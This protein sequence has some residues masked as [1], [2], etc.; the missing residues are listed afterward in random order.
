MSVGPAS[1]GG[2]RAWLCLAPLSLLVQ[3]GGPLG[4]LGFVSPGVDG[5]T[6][7]GGRSSCPGPV[8]LTWDGTSWPLPPSGICVLRNH[9]IG[10]LAQLSLPG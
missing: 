7:R 9:G 10:F 8:H 1:A 3:K 5:G 4:V 2:C 6:R